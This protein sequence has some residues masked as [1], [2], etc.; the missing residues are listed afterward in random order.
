M[1]TRCWALP[2]ACLTF[3]AL[4]IAQTT[5]RLVQEIIRRAQKGVTNFPPKPHKSWVLKSLNSKGLEP[6][7]RLAKTL[8]L[9][10]PRRAMLTLQAS[11]LTNKRCDGWLNPCDT[12]TLCRCVL[13]PFLSHFSSS[14]S[15]LVQMPHPT[16]TGM[17]T[18]PGFPLQWC[19]VNLNPSLYC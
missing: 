6:S 12:T 2:D 13:C 4:C 11:R 15:P 10:I 17:R 5:S 9:T 18:C 8:S 19:V 3:P 1:R 16:T 14:S 7:T